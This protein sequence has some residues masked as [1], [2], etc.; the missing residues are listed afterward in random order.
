MLK[1]EVMENELVRL[2]EMIDL[3]LDGYFREDAPQKGL[4]EA[5]RYSL[6]AGGKRIRG[7][8]VLKFAESCGGDITAA[9]PFACAVEML[10][11]YSLIHDDLPCMDDDDLRRGKPTNH[12]VFGEW[13]ATLAGD[14]L[15][16]AAF[17]TVLYSPLPAEARAEAAAVLA[18]AAA[19]NGICG[20]QY[21]D[22][23]G[24]CRSL[25]ADEIENIHKMKTAAMIAAASKMGVIAGGGNAV[26]LA[27]AE[28]YADSVGLA[29]QIRDDILDLTSTEEILGKPIG[30]DKKSEK[31]TFVTA[32]GLDEC[33][34]IISRETEKAK[35]AITEAFSRP[36]FL[37]WL[38]DYLSRR[39]Y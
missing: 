35:E 6:L 29:F 1:N 25:S 30:S 18:Y 39:E 34:R 17:E 14:A 11:A 32:F 20:G 13:K 9:M 26:Q 22:M 10:H 16:A 24:E 3:S 5:M 36:E 2:R 33:E 21:L 28:K 23:D 19:E 27:A 38:A 15:Q 12:K 4:L 31:S 37:I 8:L 7:I